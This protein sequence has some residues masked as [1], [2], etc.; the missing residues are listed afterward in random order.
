MVSRHNALAARHA[1]K[2]VGGVYR[3]RELDRAALNSALKA[4]IRIL[5]SEPACS[6]RVGEP[7]DNDDAAAD[8]D[9]SAGAKADGARV[10]QGKEA[11]SGASYVTESPTMDLFCPSDNELRYSDSDASV[12]LEN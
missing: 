3:K 10:T 7:D 6:K 4:L 5:S 8:G 12:A 11:K 2:P 1:A 9:P